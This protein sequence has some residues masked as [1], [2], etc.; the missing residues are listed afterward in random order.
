M[1]KGF[2]DSSRNKEFHGFPNLNFQMNNE[3]Y[4]FSGCTFW[5]SSESGL[6][7]Q[8]DNT[9]LTS[10]V[11]KI[12][13]IRFLQSTAGNQ[14][15]YFSAIPAFNNYPAV[16]FGVGSKFMTTIRPAGFNSSWTL[17]G[18]GQRT[19]PL[20]QVHIVA[21]SGGTTN[22]INSGGHDH[23]GFG[24][25]FNASQTGIGLYNTTNIRLIGST[26]EDTS[27]HIFVIN[28]KECVVDG[29]RYDVGNVRA[30]AAI[31]ALGYN[32]GAQNFGY[33]TDLIIY[34]QTI[35]GITL[36][37]RINSKYAIY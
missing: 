32:N 7:T 37:D 20:E 36:C 3:A 33:L 35:D 22:S 10:W 18:V 15:T 8:T 12:S 11:D 4:G 13:N 23:W 31:N 16:F 2:S 27:A 24:G 6:S 26:V 17:V 21:H 19:G 30:P 14:F 28:N 1:F 34:A 9:L 5:L 29:V 25:S